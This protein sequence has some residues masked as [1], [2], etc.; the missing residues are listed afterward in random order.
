ML[1]FTPYSKNSEDFDAYDASSRDE[2][3]P[4]TVVS[5]KG[6]NKYSNFDTASS[7]YVYAPDKAEDVPAAV[8][9]QFGAGRMQHGDFQWDFN[10][11]VDDASYDVNQPLKTAVTNYKSQ[12]IKIFGE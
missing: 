5:K 4:E 2:Q 9:G 6:G 3:V 8:A 7:M 12:L 11:S 10:D 1:R